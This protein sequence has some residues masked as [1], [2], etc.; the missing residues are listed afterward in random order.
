MI[1]RRHLYVL[2]FVV[3]L[4]GWALSLAAQD[5]E[6]GRSKLPPPDLANIAYG[7][8]ARNV[9]DVW[10]A[11][12]A[13]SAPLLLYF[14]G[15]GFVTGSK[16]NLPASLL[17]ACL[18]AGI[19][20]A[21]ANYRLSPE[22]VFPAHYH[23][24]ARALQFARLH[25]SEWHIDPRRVA[26]AGSSAGAGTSLWIAFHDDLADPSSDDPVARQSTR[27]TCVMVAGA[28]PTYDPA[29][30]RET[31]GESAARHPAL[32]RMYGLSPD[33]VDTPRAHE[34]Y[35]AAAPL[36]YLTADDPPVFAYY[37]ESWAPVPP[38]SRAGQGIHHPNLGRLL[39][40]RME[41]LQLECVLVHKGDPGGSVIRRELAFLTKH[42][43]L[44]A[45]GS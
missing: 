21:A 25:A 14:H 20:V 36:T 35:Q 26:L 28:Q 7:P 12:S 1:T 8:H 11:P 27:V 24:C 33:E 18:R 37:T 13:G 32:T 5:R 45:N 40:K 22:V 16:E 19:S 41:A 44:Q 29:V 3:C 2:R 38:G 9:M 6:T 15:G 39:Q 34:L 10:F 42:L 43:G 23:D 30:I 31:A 17:R 4:A